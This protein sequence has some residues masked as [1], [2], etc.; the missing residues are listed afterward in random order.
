M[1]KNLPAMW[2]NGFDLWVRSIP[3]RRKWQHTP[4]ILTGVSLGQ[5]SLVGY[6]HWGHKELGTT[7]QLTLTF[8]E[9]KSWFYSPTAIVSSVQFSSVAWSC[10]TLC[11]PMNHSTPGLPVRHQ[12]PEFTQTHVHRVDDAIQPSHP[13]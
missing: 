4:V 5:R 9:S 7:E 13:L 10:P 8:K 12:L 3:W 2:D 6:I 11:G 1:V